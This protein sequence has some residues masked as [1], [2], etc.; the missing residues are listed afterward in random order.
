MSDTLTS[1]SV[2]LRK[3]CCRKYGSIDD[4]RALGS[5]NEWKNRV[6]MKKNDEIGSLCPPEV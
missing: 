3:G 6:R 4:L 2:Y 5:S 1:D